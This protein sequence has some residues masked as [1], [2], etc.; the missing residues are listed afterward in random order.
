[1]RFV[2]FEKIPN[3]SKEKFYVKKLI[4]LIAYGNTE[5]RNFFFYAT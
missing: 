5:K 4:L 1:M 2:W 3:I